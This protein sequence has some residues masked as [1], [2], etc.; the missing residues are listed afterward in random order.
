MNGFDL[1][2][3]NSDI[4]QAARAMRDEMKQRIQSLSSSQRNRLYRSL[5]LNTGKK[6]GLIYK[7]GFKLKRHGVFME[8]GV[9]RGYNMNGG[10]VVRTAKGPQKKARVPK[11]WFN[12]SVDAHAG[13]LADAAAKHYADLAMSRLK[14]L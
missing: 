1:D 9:G 7:L 11:P 8:K 10:S 4:S 12:P 14:I 13:N 3:F 6:D 5:R 2:Q